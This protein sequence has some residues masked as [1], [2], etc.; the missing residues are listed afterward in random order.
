MITLPGVDPRM[1]ANNIVPYQP[2]HPGELLKEEIEYR[3]VTQKQLAAQTGISYAVLN[4]ILNCKRA[5]TTEYALLF[6]AAL[7]IEAGMWI[8]MQ[9]SY[10]MQV[11]KRDKSFTRRLENVRKLAASVL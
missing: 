8:R 6:E 9:A 10:N 11:L 3:G 2:V 5:V 1:I 7:G 4:Q